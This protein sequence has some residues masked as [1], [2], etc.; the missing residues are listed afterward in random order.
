MYNPGCGGDHEH[1]ESGERAPKQTKRE[2]ENDSTHTLT[3]TGHA[4][5]QSQ[6]IEENESSNESVAMTMELFAQCATHPEVVRL[7]SKLLTD[8]SWKK[9]C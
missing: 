6:I 1:S 4:R 2:L 5:D 3:D 8:K 7:V 9:Q